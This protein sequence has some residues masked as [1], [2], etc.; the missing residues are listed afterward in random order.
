MCQLEN[1]TCNTQIIVSDNTEYFSEYLQVYLH[2]Q[3]ANWYYNNIVRCKHLID[4]NV[5]QSHQE[6][7]I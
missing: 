2:F 5:L 1:D 6:L 4:R 7:Q 3:S